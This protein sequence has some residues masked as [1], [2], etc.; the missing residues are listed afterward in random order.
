MSVETD[1]ARVPLLR[2]IDTSRD[3][4]ETAEMAETTEMIES[5]RGTEMIGVVSLPLRRISTAMCLGRK[6]EHPALPSTLCKTQPSSP[7]KLA[8]PT[9]A[10][11]GE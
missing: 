10:N 5:G 2:L 4:V 7:T 11:G 3:L 8:S 6:A 1:D 9:S